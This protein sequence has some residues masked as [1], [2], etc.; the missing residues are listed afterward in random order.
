MISWGCRPKAGFWGAIRL[1]NDNFD[2]AG[3]LIVALFLATWILSYI[4]YR[5]KRY[6]EIEAS[7]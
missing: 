3:G 7:S 2:I 6:H 4:I 1:V 5:A